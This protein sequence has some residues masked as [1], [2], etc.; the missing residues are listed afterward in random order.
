VKKPQPQSNEKSK[1]TVWLRTALWNHVRHLAIDQGR[2]ANQI[3]EEALGAYLKNLPKLG[4][5]R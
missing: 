5:Q 4:Q 3:V 2:N 1:A